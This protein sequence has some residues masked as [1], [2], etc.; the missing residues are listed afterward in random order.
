MK[1]EINFKNEK[2]TI[3]SESPIKICEILDYF[4]FKL[5]L[6][7]NF[8]LFLFNKFRFYTIDEYLTEK[9]FNEQLF[10]T[11]L[12]K[13][14]IDDDFAKQLESKKIEEII[15][16][17]TEADEMIVR[18]EITQCLT[19]S[20]VFSIEGRDFVPLSLRNL[21]LQ[22]RIVWDESVDNSY[23]IE[24]ISNDEFSEMS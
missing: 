13:R 6:D 4:K 21:M 23:R 8:T 19:E 11:I 14:S 20:F 7:T 2:F 1:F 18:K 24:Y 9:D 15:M 17:A 22:V 12:K 16:E 10:M 3:K 5:G